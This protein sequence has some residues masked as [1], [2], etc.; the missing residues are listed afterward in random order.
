MWEE[1]RDFLAI[2]YRYNTRLDTP[3]W[4]HCR[5]D[6]ALHGAAR[7]VD[8]YQEN[9][10]SNAFATDLLTP[11]KSIF[12]L[13]GFFALLLGQKVPHR[14]VHPLTSEEQKILA[15]V[16]AANTAEARAGFDVTESLALIRGP[17]WRWTPG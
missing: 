12:Q 16:R 2:H 9:G 13:E 10:P 17:Y 4:E 6:T 15:S 3:F 7:I 11:E 1:I 5:R 14:R 8:F